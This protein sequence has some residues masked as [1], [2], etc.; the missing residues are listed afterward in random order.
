MR[1]W[2]V[3][4]LLA[5]ALG[6]GVSLAAANAS[7]LPGESTAVEGML[8]QQVQYHENRRHCRRVCY[9]RLHR[10]HCDG[11]WRERCDR[12]GHHYRGHHDRRHNDRY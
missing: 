4:S 11:F 8:A 9:G 12:R 3:G 1:Y 5:G 6:L 2:I 10:G 7:S